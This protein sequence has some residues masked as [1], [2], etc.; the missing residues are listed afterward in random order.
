MSELQ[1]HHIL[2]AIKDLSLAARRT[3]DGFMAGINKSKVKGPGLEFSQ[4]RS[5]QPGDDLRWLDWK[6][7][8]R[9]DRYYIR[10]SEIETSISIR[11]LVDASNSMAHRDGASTKLDYA[12]LLAASLGWLAHM[13]GDSFGLYVF[14]EGDV[15]SLPSRKDPQHLA[16]FFYQLENIRPGG[17]MG[18]PTQYKHI[19]TGDQKRELLVFI[20]DMYEREGEISRL[21]E[22]LAALRH[23]IIVFHLIGKNELEM[24]YKGYHRVQDLETGEQVPFNGV[25][26]QAAYQERL[27]AWLAGVRMQLLDK[28]I[29]Y[30]MVRMDQSPGD[31]LRDFLKQR[32]KVTG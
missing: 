15:F 25:L 5:Y 17:R 11:L 3:I 9:S 2:M 7:Y 1:D 23:E 12:R 26:A 4:Y 30:T 16:R 22:V 6:R 31:A 20:T 21:L 29:A 13:Q 28:Q 27:Q 10:E 14:Q 18:D 8:A 32:Q 24:D 19:F